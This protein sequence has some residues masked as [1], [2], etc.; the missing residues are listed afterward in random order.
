V[1]S[2]SPARSPGSS[3][4]SSC[5]SATRGC[6]CNRPPHEADAFVTRTDG[7]TVGANLSLG[8]SDAARRVAEI[9]LPYQS[10]IAA[11]VAVRLAR[12]VRPAIVSVHSFTP[13][14][15]DRPEPR[16]WDVSVLFGRDDRLA[17]ALRD[18]LARDPSLTVGV[19]EPYRVDD[20]GDY[21][22]PVHAERLGLLHVEIEVRQDRIATAADEAAWGARLAGAIREAMERLRQGEAA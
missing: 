11:A 15:G 5:S 18:V 14:H 3:G 20:S 2:A 17:L 1:R 7:V 9:F 10:R 16:P 8:P 12:G 13:H 21:A 19:N 22:I 6:D 4:R